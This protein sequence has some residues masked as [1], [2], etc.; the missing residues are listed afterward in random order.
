[1]TMRKLVAITM[2]LGCGSDPAPPAMEGTS[3]GADGS[4]TS[5][6]DESSS[7]ST[8]SESSS[9]T[10]AVDPGMTIDP[11]PDCAAPGDGTVGFDLVLDGTN[12]LEGLPPLDFYLNLICIGTV[13]DGGNGLLAECPDAKGNPRELVLS[14]T[15]VDLGLALD[16]DELVFC[17]V[18]AIDGPALLE[19]DDFGY[20]FE[21]H[22]GNTIDAP[23]LVAGGR[24]S[25]VPEAWFPAGF[26]AAVGGPEPCPVDGPTFVDDTT[27]TFRQHRTLEFDFAGEVV[28]ALGGTSFEQGD[29]AFEVGVVE[30]TYV[31]EALAAEYPECAP[32][33]VPPASFAFLARGPA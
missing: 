20:V 15:G 10:T 27:C 14:T 1:M 7:S 30:S 25:F 21:V 12:V 26:T 29:L 11:H 4:S 28:T 18:H 13:T 8:S 32:D 31:V 16:P 6:T 17:R 22:R 19:N 3:T 23:L 24:G 33:P 9:S 2:V 5:T